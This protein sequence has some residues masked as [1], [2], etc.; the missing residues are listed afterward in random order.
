MRASKMTFEMTERERALLLELIES[1]EKAGI[2]GLGH[3]DSR[4]FKKLLKKRLE[5][6]ASLRQKIQS[7][8]SQAA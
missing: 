6:L 2:H 4:D 3:A 7:S 5:I 8:G 1:A